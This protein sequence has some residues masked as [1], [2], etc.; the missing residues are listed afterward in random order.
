MVL[1]DTGTQFYPYAFKS[2]Q[3][4]EHKNSLYFFKKESEKIN[5]SGY[6]SLRIYCP[7]KFKFSQSVAM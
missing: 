7:I 3:K 5:I 1:L 4:P 2:A 6:W